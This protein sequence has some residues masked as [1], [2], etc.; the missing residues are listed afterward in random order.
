MDAR[1]ARRVQRLLAFLI[2]VDLTLCL[3]GFLQPALWFQVV[4]GVPVNDAQGYLRRAAA[5]WLSFLLIQI[6]AYRRFRREPLWLA[7]V[8]GVRLSDT[9]A[10][11]THLLFAADVSALGY[12][13][14]LPASPVN[15]LAGVFL[16]RAADRFAP[17]VVNPGDT[18]ALPQQPHQE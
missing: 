9:L 12:L 13:C 18:R 14:L 8:A 6:V 4:H 7:V 16:L 2:L 11:W 15:L 3:V 17:S 10:D 5:A 1:A